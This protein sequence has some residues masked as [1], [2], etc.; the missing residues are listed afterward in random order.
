MSAG[1]LAMF[2]TVVLS[3][4]GVMHLYVFARLVSVPWVA[5][6]ISRSHLF[7]IGV[8]LGAS[9][10]LARFMYAW[11]WEGLPLALEYIG[12]YWM[13]TIFLIFA[14]LLVTDVVTLGGFLMSKWA[15]AMRGWAVVLA[16]VL[17]VVGIVQGFRAPVVRDYEVRLPGLPKDYDGLV[18]V[19]ISDLHLG[20]LLGERW[21]KG[22]VDQVNALKPELI[23]VNGDVIDGNVERVEPL[24][25]TLK[26]LNAP[27]G[28]FAVSGNH[29]YY[30]GLKESLALFQKAGFTI[31]QDRSAKVV[32]GLT[33]SGVD[34]LTART[35]H[36][37]TG[38]VVNNALANRPPGGTIYLSH[39]PLQ[40]TT[41]AAAGAGLMLCGHTHNGQIWPFNF[42]VRS[43]YSYIG[44]RYQVGSMAVI[45]CRGTGTWGPRMRLWWP[46][47]IVRIKLRAA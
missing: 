5:S 3:I 11:H 17:A 26:K 44:G 30:A 18:M 34:D 15:P 45:I 33:I 22:I 9:Y 32:T 40:A 10:P 47:E 16:G 46:S 13:G 31:L 20:T 1:R 37:N 6:H 39:S 43:R 38:L 2:L 29:E 27:L 25:T 12:T 8:C 19:E 21:L 36:E 14:G 35:G 42:L 7:M 4:W 28:V 23:V 41:A 24:V